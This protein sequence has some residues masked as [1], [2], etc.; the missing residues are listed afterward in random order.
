MEFAHLLITRSLFPRFLWLWWLFETPTLIVY[1][2][3]LVNFFPFLCPA[4]YAE[5]PSLGGVGWVGRGK[6][7][8]EDG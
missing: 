7:V 5:N 6:R 8:D 2:I 4:A 3:C 1:F